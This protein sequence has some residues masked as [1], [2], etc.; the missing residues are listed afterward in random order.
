MAADE[1][2]PSPSPDESPSPSPGGCGAAKRCPPPP[3]PGQTRIPCCAGAL[4]RPHTLSSCEQ[5]AAAF[6]RVPRPD[7]FSS[8]APCPCRLRRE[9]FPRPRLQPLP[10]CV[11]PG[12]PRAPRATAPSQH[13]QL[14]SLLSATCKGPPQHAIPA[15]SCKLACASM[16]WL[17]ASAAHNQRSVVEALPACCADP[18]YS[19]SPSPDES[20]SPSPDESPSPSPDESPSPSPDESPSPSPDESPS[21]SPRRFS[22]PQGGPGCSLWQ[23]QRERPALRPMRAQPATLGL[24]PSPLVPDA[25]PPFLCCRRGQGEVSQPKR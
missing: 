23:A 15:R 14:L 20:P 10:R 11:L 1:E 6:C 21:P 2:S 25:N 9:P 19:P 13:G 5:R 16:C 18:D 7:L 8:R 17:A 3:S 24:G 12:V 22:E 4:H